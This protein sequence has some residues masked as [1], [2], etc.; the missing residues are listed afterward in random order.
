MIGKTLFLAFLCFYFLTGCSGEREKAI[1]K[2]KD[3]PQPAEKK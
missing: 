3:K 2:D 1:N